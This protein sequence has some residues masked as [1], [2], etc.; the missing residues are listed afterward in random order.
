MPDKGPLSGIRVIDFGRYIAAPY[1]G[2]LLADMGADVIRVDRREGSEDRYLAPITEDGEGSGF[3]SLNRNKRSL[4]LDPAKRESAEVIQRLGKRADVVLANLPI[5]VLRK[6]RLDYDSLRAVKPDIILARISA[7]GPDGPYANRVG[8]D[9]VAQA[10]SGAMALTGF[11]GTP[12]RALI[13]FEDYGTALHTAFGVMVALYHR[14]RTGEG[15]IVDGSLL[16]TG[17]TFA[18][19]LLAERAVIGVERKQKGNASFYAAP[20]D[21]YQAQDG[22]IVVSVVGEE[23]FARWARLVG[24]E[25]FIAD[26]RFATDLL[27]ADHSDI[28]TAAMNAWLKIRTSTQ[29]IAELETARI[30]AGPVL[31]LDQV[32][33]DPQV[34]ARK[35]LQSFEYPGAPSPV[36]L[37]TIPVQ[38]SV[39]PGE[40]RRRAPTLGEHTDEILKEIGYSEQE[41]TE[42]RKGEVV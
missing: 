29:A 25:D 14:Q 39:T 6:M 9:M 37:A 10:M 35:L 42:L 41:I 23:M 12:M 5:D 33:A 31:N 15:Q 2:M 19:G 28:I 18:Q 21:A 34:K 36:P 8:F 17:I 38:L 22:W 20:A 27:R 24:R 3:L 32:M 11:P 16:A 40:I 26:P 4:T 30:P 1:C 7:F 13:P